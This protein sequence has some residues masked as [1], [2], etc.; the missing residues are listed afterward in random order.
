MKPP[1]KQMAEINIAFRGPTRSSHLPNNAAEAPSVNKAIE[2]IQPMAVSF[3][4]PAMEASM[5]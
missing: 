1:A 4:S 5:P 2:K 3:Q